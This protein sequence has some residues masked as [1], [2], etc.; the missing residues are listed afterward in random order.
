MNIAI[1][2][3][4]IGSEWPSLKR[5]GAVGW[6]PW[7]RIVTTE[8]TGTTP[9]GRYG[10]ADQR[11]QQRGLAA[12]ELSEA[13]DKEARLQQPLTFGLCFALERIV[14]H[15]GSDLRESLELSA[16]NTSCT[17]IDGFWRDRLGH[18]RAASALAATPNAPRP[19]SSSSIRT[20]W[21]YFAT[22]SDLAIDPVLM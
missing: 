10:L 3:T 14:A 19:A 6:S 7:C 15:L 22:R 9:T 5:T 11:I 20:S 8:A 4:A 2:S 17:N 1:A 12:F 16:N 21:L 13:R 18:P